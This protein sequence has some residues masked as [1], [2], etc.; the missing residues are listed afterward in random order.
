[1]TTVTFL[2]ASGGTGTTTLAALTL[3][4]LTTHNIRLP[5]VI[6]EDAAAF[7]QRSGLQL[8]PSPRGGH[9][10]I[11]GGRYDEH[12]AATALTR[13]Y[14]V[15]VGAHTREGMAALTDSVSEVIDRFGADANR[16]N[17]PV[18]V[19][20]FGRRRATSREMPVQMRLPFDSALATG[21]PLPLAMQRLSSGTKSTLRQRWNPWVLETFALR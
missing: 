21:G 6:A 9:Q 1:M 2:G 4:L 14:L 16:R 12:K 8:L 3:H 10:L 19:S 18:V 13:G 11:D 17:I 20:A 15:L 7:D 5:T